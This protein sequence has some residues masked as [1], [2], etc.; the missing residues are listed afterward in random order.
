MSQSAIENPAKF[1]TDLGGL[2]DSKVVAIRWDIAMASL[3]LALDDI[4]A[5]FQGLPEYRGRSPATV[6]FNG[7]TGLSLNFDAP[8]DGP[9]RIYEIECNNMGNV[10]S[11]EVR[12]APGGR[13]AFSS[14]SVDLA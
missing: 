10:L 12:L 14:K 6:R 4:N 3:S 9:L 13:L 11:L 5:N 2:H 8:I 1:F 7:V